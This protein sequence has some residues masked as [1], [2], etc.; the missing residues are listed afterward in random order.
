MSL[1]IVGSPAQVSSG[2]NYTPG[3]GSN[4]LVLMIAFA[5]G[6]SA[7]P[8]LTNIAYNSVTRT[9]AV[10][11]DDG[12]G[13]NRDGI[14]I[15]IFKESELPAGAQ[16]VTPTW[17]IAPAAQTILC[18]TIQDADQTTTVRTTANT[19]GNST[20]V[21]LNLTGLTVGDLC[22]GGTALRGNVG[23][24][25][26]TNNSW[27]EDLDVNVGTGAAHAANL[28]ADG[29]PET[30]SASFSTNDH[31]AAAIAIIAAAASI[32]IPVIQNHR[33]RH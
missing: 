33:L 12:A 5:K 24:A 16:A 20:S 13:G 9:P 2:G 1:G 17:S 3:A 10:G 11:A 23:G 15:C 4:R 29:T 30:Y 14:G 8:S 26:T 22:I 27:A 28:I 18:Y 32:S 31:A 25:I 19:F 6:A 7:A 21:S